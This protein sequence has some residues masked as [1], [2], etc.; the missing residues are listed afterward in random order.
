MAIDFPSEV[1]GTAVG[2]LVYSFLALALNGLVIWLTWVHRER[3]SYVALIADILFLSTAT[4]IASQLHFYIDWEDVVTT[5]WRASVA[6][7]KNPQMSISNGAVGVDLGLWYFRQYSFSVASTLVCFWAFALLQSV[8]GWWAKPHLKRLFDRINAGGKIISFLLP[9][10]T[11]CLLQSKTIQKSLGAFMFVA[12]VILMISLAFGAVVLLGILTRY[13]QS[14]RQ[15][16]SFNVQ[17]GKS[18]SNNSSLPSQFAAPQN[19]PSGIYDRWLMTRF[20]IAFIVL[21]IFELTNMLFQFTGMSNSNED[22]TRTSP[23]F[24]VERAKETTILFLP[25]PAPSYLLFIVFGTTAA[26]RRHMYETFVPR[27]WQRWSRTSSEPVAR[28]WVLSSSSPKRSSRSTVRARSVTGPSERPIPPRPV[29]IQLEDLEKGIRS[30]PTNESDDTLP[31][32]PLMKPTY[33]RTH[34][35]RATQ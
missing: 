21:S 28:P 5:Q 6:N 24:S 35:R 32:L 13:L 31:M 34:A 3:V 22:A 9:I 17:Y 1:V 23:N 2:V 4:C 10:L 16:V 29:T 15:L 11:I 26:F 20:T 33:Q 19:K 14:R 30:P 25:G 12:N 27:R 7:P 8:Y 18:S